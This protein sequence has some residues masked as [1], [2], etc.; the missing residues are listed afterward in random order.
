MDKISEALHNI[1]GLLTRESNGNE[2]TK[3]A[4]NQI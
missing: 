4:F 2:H 1:D 3:L